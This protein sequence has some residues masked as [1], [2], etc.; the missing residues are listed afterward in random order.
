MARKKAR[1]VRRTTPAA[2]GSQRAKARSPKR[3]KGGGIHQ[4]AA[5]PEAA[6]KSAPSFARHETFAPRFGWVR[7]GYAAVENRPEFFLQKD[8]HLQIGVGKNQARSIR[9]WCHA[10]GVLQDF[11]RPAQRLIESVHSDLGRNLLKRSG[12]DPYL[13]DPASLWLLHWRLVRE[14]WTA[15]AWHYAFTLM[16]DL[17]F[18]VQRLTRALGEYVAMAFPGARVAESSLSKDASCIARMYSVARATDL[19]EESIQSPFADLGL[20]SPTNSAQESFRFNV[21]IKRNLPAAIVAAAC[22]E[23][24]AAVAPTARTV[25]IS[26]LISDAG[27][28]GMAFKLSESALTEYLD[29]ASRETRAFWLSDAAGLVQVGYKG[30]P[31]ALVTRILDAYY[32]SSR[33]S[34]AA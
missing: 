26:R 8:A 3:T 21:G 22:I 34:V 32:V 27:S 2:R 6:G 4:L 28:P 18:T 13:E 1:P 10:L 7:K 5:A 23:F 16:P 17:D 12:W 15:T 25:G 30:D 20:I 33:D 14:P 29:Q 19:T 31:S 24:A 9:Y 11:R